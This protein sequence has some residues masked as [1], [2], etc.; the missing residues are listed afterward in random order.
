MIIKGVVEGR[1]INYTLDINEPNVYLIG[2]VTGG[3]WDECMTDWKFQVPSTADGEFVSPAFAAAADATDG[4]RI[5]VKIPEADW[6]KSEFMVFDG[7]IKYRGTGND[8]DRITAGAGQKV[9]LNF[10]NDTGKIE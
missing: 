5:Y 1:N 8:Q 6:W 9:Y 10:S 4:V 7:K 3:M 2:P